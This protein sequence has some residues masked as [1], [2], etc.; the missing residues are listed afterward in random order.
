MW[1]HWARVN[2][3]AKAAS[4]AKRDSRFF[5]VEFGSNVA[6]YAGMGGM[7]VRQVTEAWR[8]NLSPEHA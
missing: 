5:M 8:L 3:T 4:R 7:V 6:S 2:G 1:V